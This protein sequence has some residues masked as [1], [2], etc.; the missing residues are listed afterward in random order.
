MSFLEKRYNIKGK[1]EFLHAG[2]EADGCEWGIFAEPRD[3]VLDAARR[4]ERSEHGG[5]RTT[6]VEDA[7]VAGRLMRM[8][9]QRSID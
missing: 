9:M 3:S 4:H 7:N 6:V 5:R 2:C 8:R 1:P